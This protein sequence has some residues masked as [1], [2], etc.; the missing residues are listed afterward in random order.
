MAPHAR[1]TDSLPPTG[2]RVSPWGGPTETL[3]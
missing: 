1:N 2:G 3:P